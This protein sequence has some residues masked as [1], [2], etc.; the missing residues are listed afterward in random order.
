M[1][2]F[3]V[4]RSRISSHLAGQPQ[5]EVPLSRNSIFMAGGRVVNESKGKVSFSSLTEL[6]LL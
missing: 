3:I 2:H 6:L 5:P 1:L 4:V